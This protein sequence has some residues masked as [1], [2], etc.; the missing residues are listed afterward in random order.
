MVDNI[1]INTVIPVLF[2][3]GLHTKD[4]QY[5]EKAIRWLAELGPEHNSITKSWN[6]S[7]IANANALDSQ[8]LIQLTNHYC[9]EKSCLQCVVGN[10][11]LKG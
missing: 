2:A 9:K 10:K 5:K 7:G 4:E 11:L 8:A 1:I 6:G 3:Y